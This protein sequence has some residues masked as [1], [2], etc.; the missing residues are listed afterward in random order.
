MFNFYR[1]S[2]IPRLPERPNNIDRF[3]SYPILDFN[4]ERMVFRWKYRWHLKRNFELHEAQDTEFAK[5]CRLPDKG[6]A[7]AEYWMKVAQSTNQE[8][9][10]RKL[11]LEHLAAYFESSCYQAAKNVQSQSRDRDWEE[12]LCIARIKIY[13]LDN[14]GKILEKYDFRQG[15]NLDTYVQNI[16]EK[17]IKTE[18]SVGKYSR[19]RL[20]AQK[21]DKE[22]KEA[23]QKHGYG[24]AQLAQ[25][26]F[27]RKYF[28]QVYLINK[29]KN[30]HRPTGQ[31]WPLPDLED[32]Q[33]AAKYYNAEKSLPAAPHE[34][35]ASG[36]TVTGEQIKQ[37]MEICLE[38]LKKYKTNLSDAVSIE[39]LNES[40]IDIKSKESDR[41]N[42]YS[43]RDTDESPSLI[44][45]TDAFFQEEIENVKAKIEQ[46]IQKRKLQT[47]HKKIPI[48]YYGIG[49]TQAET[50][51]ILGI[52]QANIARH[53]ANYYELPLLEKLAAIS[54]PDE[55]VKPFISRWLVKDY[56]S[57]VRSDLIQ[58]TL[59]EAINKLTLEYR[60]IL[61]LRYG[62]NL[63]ENQISVRY[64]IS[65]LE[66]H[67]RISEA[68]NCLE[69]VLLKVIQEWLNKYV[70]SW[71][72]R[73]YKQNICST[74]TSALTILSRDC[75]EVV[76]YVYREGWTIEQTAKQLKLEN[77]RVKEIICLAKIELR[78][79]LLKWMV[80]NL[81][82]SLEKESQLAKVNGIVQEWLQNAFNSN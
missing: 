34:V 20:L 14:F 12:Y 45:R 9:N 73:F 11:A 48:F 50:A 30:P 5:L 41:V 58:A 29:V 21:S 1:K 37:W 43:D 27:A 22:L 82:V 75:Q 63:S 81:D 59:V 23:L 39:F 2:D 76:N 44:A 68:R 78:G 61:Q 72:Y 62:Q 18:V 69:S 54:R 6:R 65:E 55:W 15:A 31:K 49:L 56:T 33:E 24:Q 67:Q 32:F 70:R 26:L 35:S 74:L 19:W 8:I 28:K 13:D 25:Y 7:I 46:Q 64:S 40:G 17:T 79:S 4:N 36:V 80:E 53:I 3:S 42:L 51:N 71:L 47:Y 77:H 57:P 66:V 52:N 38:A 16:L 60:E 10:R